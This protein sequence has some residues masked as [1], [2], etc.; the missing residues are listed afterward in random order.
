MKKYQ[1]P[2]NK[3]AAGVTLLLAVIFMTAC[4]NNNQLPA[5]TQIAATAI[6]LDTATPIPA[7]VTITPTSS[8]IPSTATPIPPTATTI[9]PTATPS[10]APVT[11]TLEPSLTPTLL[12]EI[13]ELN[14]VKVYETT[15]TLPTYPL[16]DYLVEQIDPIYNM[17]VFYFD[18]ASY[19]AANPTPSAVD[20]TGVVLENPYLR[21]TFLPELGGRLYSAFIKSSKQ[22][23]FYHNPVVK[24]SRYGILQPYEAN[25]WLATGGM[26]WAY[27]TQE[28]GYRFGVPW[29]YSISQDNN[30]T[31][32]TLSDTGSKRVGLTVKVTL[33]PDKAT[34]SVAPLLIN[35][36]PNEVPVQL[37]INAALAL[38]SGSMSP[39]TQFTIPA[40]QITV[41]SRGEDGWSVPGEHETSPWPQVGETDLRDYQQWANYLGFFVS[42]EEAAFIGAYNPI[43][44][45][46]MLRLAPQTEPG[47]NKLFAFGADFPDRSYTDDGSQ[48]FEMWGGA[49]VGFW[50]EDDIM[51]PIGETL[52]WQESWW[53][54]AQLGGLTGASEHIAFDLTRQGDTYTLTAL[55][56]QAT[57]GRLDITAGELSLLNETFSAD[58]AAPL[59]WDFPAAAA[60]FNIQFTDNN[61]NTLLNHQANQ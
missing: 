23:V 28:H 31:T 22:E 57:T 49:N 43:T 21:L 8:P 53:P 20:Y 56:A 30:G 13:Q 46:G 2:Q 61:G 48:Y 6:P 36:S 42:N 37:W 5:P 29:D 58:P 19:D 11:P 51:V 34:F 40:D 44:D 10:P 4:A 32:I 24:A 26:D 47:S 55:V 59:Q 15:I 17:P 18:R 12:A 1:Y 45:L 52:G 35:N 41:H 25:W 60:P 3:L 50:P 38:T 14:E 39:Q 16:K 33:A 7:T 9:P 54:L 27:P